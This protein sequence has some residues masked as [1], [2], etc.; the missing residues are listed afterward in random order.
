MTNPAWKPRARETP[1]SSPWTP[2]ISPG[3][4]M[5]DISPRRGGLDHDLRP[6]IHRPLPRGL[7]EAAGIPPARR[8]GQTALRPAAARAQNGQPGAAP[9]LALSLPPDGRVRRPQ[10]ARQLRRDADQ[11]SA[12]VLP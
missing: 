1:A 10:M 7:P 9:D 8:A 3:K 11:G 12:D 2:V 6:R 4:P 5:A